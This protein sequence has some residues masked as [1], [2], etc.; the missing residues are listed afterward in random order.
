MKDQRPLVGIGVIIIKSNKILLLKRKG[1]HGEGTW[2]FIGGH[3]EHGETLEEGAKREV[4]EEAGIT[5]K[6]LKRAGFTEDFFKKEDK[7]YITLFVIAEPDKGE[8]KNMEPDKSTE[9]KW[10]EWDKFPSPL[11]PPVVNLRKQGFNPFA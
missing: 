6:N 3:L 7:H 10:F 4:K 1:S 9:I 11:F 2:A 8:A 5:I